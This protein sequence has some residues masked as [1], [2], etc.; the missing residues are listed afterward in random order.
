MSGWRQTVSHS[1]YAQGLLG[2]HDPFGPSPFPVAITPSLLV[3]LPFGRVSR[4]VWNTSRAFPYFLSYF[5][6]CSNDR[7]T[8]VQRCSRD[9]PGASSAA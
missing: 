2:P 4:L 5:I 9:V 1:R 6:Y 7:S 8:V 3:S